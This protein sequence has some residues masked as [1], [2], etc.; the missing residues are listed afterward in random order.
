MTFV[1]VRP[2]RDHLRMALSDDQLLDFDAGQYASY[3]EGKAR[4]TLTGRHGDAYR[5]QLVAARW[6]EGWRQRTLAE[7]PVAAGRAEDWVRGWDDALRE[8]VAHLRQGDL[9]P[10]GILYTDATGGWDEPR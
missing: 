3:D 2:W 10:G 5:A 6:I 9:I 7:D 4:D 8:V 1:A